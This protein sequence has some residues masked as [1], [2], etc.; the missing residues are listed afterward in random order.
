MF[1]TESRPEPVQ[2]IAHTVYGDQFDMVPKMAVI[3]IPLLDGPQHVGSSLD[4]ARDTFCVV[5]QPIVNQSG[6]LF[7]GTIGA[8]DYIGLPGGVLSVFL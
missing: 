6:Q 2:A 4:V 8:R 7:R 5:L 3:V 1:Q